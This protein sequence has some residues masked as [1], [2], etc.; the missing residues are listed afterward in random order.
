MQLE[1]RKAN[2]AGGP[3]KYRLHFIRKVTVPG[4]ECWLQGPR[5]NP[6]SDVG[7]WHIVVMQA[8]EHTVLGSCDWNDSAGPCVVAM[9]CLFCLKPNRRAPESL[10][11]GLCLVIFCLIHQFL[12]FVISLKVEMNFL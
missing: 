11:G 9:P 6:L 10:G 4:K 2:R 1:S 12:E 3:T 8:S 7:I 5:E